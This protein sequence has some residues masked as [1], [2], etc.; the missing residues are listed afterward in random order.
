MREPCGPSAQEDEEAK[1]PR[2]TCNPGQKVRLADTCHAAFCRCLFGCHRGVDRHLINQVRS[3]SKGFVEMSGVWSYVP[4][5]AA[6]RVAETWAPT[7]E[8]KACGTCLFPWGVLWSVL[9][10]PVRLS[11][12]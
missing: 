8:E 1:L 5:D 3:V 10:V 12:G 4:S 11:H 6:R 2:A 9:R 7:C